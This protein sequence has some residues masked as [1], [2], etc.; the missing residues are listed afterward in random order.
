MAY[1]GEL[2]GRFLAFISALVN[3]FPTLLFKYLLY[4][5]IMQSEIK[6]GRINFMQIIKRQSINQEK[7]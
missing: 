7:V 1:D 2:R 3:C 4:V 5:V 6:C